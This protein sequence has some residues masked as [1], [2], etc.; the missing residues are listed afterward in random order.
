MFPKVA[1]ERYCNIF[2][3]FGVVWGKGVATQRVHKKVFVRQKSAKIA[4]FTGQKR[5]QKKKRFSPIFVVQ[6]LFCVPS[7]WL[8]LYPKPPQKSKIYCNTFHL[9]PWGTF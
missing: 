9:P 8:P 7:G 3:I 2:L 6:K 1:N 4:F 5:S